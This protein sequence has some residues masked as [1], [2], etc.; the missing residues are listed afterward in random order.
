ML[1][2]ENE[3]MI[4]GFLQDHP[5]F[6]LMPVKEI[7]GTLRANQVGDGTYLRTFPDRLE[8]PDGFFA[9]VLRKVGVSERG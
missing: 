6:I 9:A 3:L 5:E 1:P 4:E 7:W 8:G 2:E